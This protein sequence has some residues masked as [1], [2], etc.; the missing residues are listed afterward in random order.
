MKIAFACGQR[1]LYVSI[2]EYLAGQFPGIDWYLIQE[3]TTSLPVL[4]KH[5]KNRVRRY[6]FVRAA[7]MIL[8]QFYSMFLSEPKSELAGVDVTFKEQ[9]VVPNINDPSCKALLETNQIDLL[10][11]MSVGIMKPGIF[12]APR[13]GAINVHPGINPRYR[14]AGG[15]FWAIYENR[16]DMVGVTI[17]SVEKKVDAGQIYFQ[18]TLPKMKGSIE[19]TLHAV[20]ELGAQG[21]VEVIKTFSETKQFHVATPKFSNT[22]DKVYGYYGLTDYLR[23]RRNLARR[24]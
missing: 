16:F 15:S 5:L 10:I 2:A 23:A 21:L 11:A 13:S 9:L 12:Q 4:I 3:D 8:L 1:G 18:A 19:E 14:G 24:G 17:H 20:F 22:A 7:D 6:G